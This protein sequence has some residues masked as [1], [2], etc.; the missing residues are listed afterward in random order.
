[1]NYGQYLNLITI[2]RDAVLEHTI[3]VAKKKKKCCI[4]SLPNANSFNIITYE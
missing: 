3:I 1:M 2:N 4:V